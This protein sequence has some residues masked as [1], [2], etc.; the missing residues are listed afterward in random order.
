MRQR[1]LL[2]YHGLKRGR[3]RQ[4]WNKYNLFNIAGLQVRESLFGKTFFQQKWKAKAMTRAYHGEHIPERQWERMFSKKFQTVINMNPQYM[5]ANDGSE[6]AAGRGSGRKQLGEE[7]T[8]ALHM[9]TPHMQMT[10]APQERRLDIAVFRALFASSARQARQ[11]VI[12]GAVTVNGKKMRHPGYLLN[13]GD[14][15]QVDP[16][17][18][19]LATGLKKEKAPPNKALK[20]TPEEEESEEP[21]DEEESSPAEPAAAPAEPLDPHAAHQAMIQELNRLRLHAKTIVDAQQIGAKHK[22]ALRQFMSNVK[23]AMAK[24][25]KIDPARISP[26]A[27]SSDTKLVD[28]LTDAL[29]AFELGLPDKKETKPAPAAEEKAE[30][31]AAE[32]KAEAP[33]GPV[34]AAVLAHKSNIRLNRDEEKI[35]QRLLEQ[36]RENPYDP[37]KPYLTPWKPR[38][39]MA[40]FAFIPRY[41]EV[42]QNIC[43]AVYLRHPVARPGRSEVPSP[44]PHVIGQLAFNW[45][46]RRR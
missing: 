2:R 30:A 22:K 34:T 6:E 5:A 44:F 27:G 7:K 41:L 40:P 13:P 20:A 43:A 11:F 45:Y 24:A 33:V 4:T 38:P 17:R 9:L 32:E 16:V 25:R 36:E 35:L 21:V 29:A 18:V 1:R 19:M 14:L 28:D 23:E 26:K 37:S 42:N 46:L 8:S 10:Y 39:Y 15:F 31:P 12:H 3:V